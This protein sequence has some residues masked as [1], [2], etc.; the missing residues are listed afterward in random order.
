MFEYVKN[1]NLI[2]PFVQNAAH[3]ILGQYF[4]YHIELKDTTTSLLFLDLIIQRTPCSHTFKQCYRP[5]CWFFI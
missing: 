2:D 5:L 3:G 1:K 4:L